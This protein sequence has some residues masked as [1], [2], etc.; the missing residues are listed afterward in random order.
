MSAGGGRGRGG[1]GGRLGNITVFWLLMRSV[2]AVA[3]V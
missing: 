3:Q 1:G 2:G